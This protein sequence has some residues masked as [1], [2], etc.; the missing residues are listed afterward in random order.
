M[1]FRPRP[2][3]VSQRPVVRRTGTRWLPLRGFV[4]NSDSGPYRISFLLNQIQLERLEPWT[5]EPCGAEGSVKSTPQSV[6]M[7]SFGAT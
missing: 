6:L 1:A 2:N 4:R 7:F 5:S 3:E